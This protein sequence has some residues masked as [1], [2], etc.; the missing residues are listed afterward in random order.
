MSEDDFLDTGLSKEHLAAI[1]LVT[2]QWSILESTVEQCLWGLLDL[3]DDRARAVTTHLTMRLRLDMLRTLSHHFDP[4]GD[5]SEQ[6]RDF[7]KDIQDDSGDRES[8][9]KRR[10]RLV[11]ARWDTKGLLSLTGLSAATMHKA[12]GKVTSN[13]KHL[14]PADMLEVARDVAKMSIRL[15]AWH[16]S[17][18]LALSAS[19]TKR[20]V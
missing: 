4:D 10:N 20:L 5:Y 1:G 11:H 6:L 7:V 16:N 2:V 12:R 15:R 13:V 3:R 19:T 17:F 18:V 8:L 14:S 9:S